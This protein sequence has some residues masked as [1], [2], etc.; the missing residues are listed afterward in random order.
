VLI[1][2]NAIAR[3]IP[4]RDLRLSATHAVYVDGALVPAAAL[5]NGV[6]IRREHHDAAISYFHIEL[7]G[8]D[9]IFAEGLPV[10][11]FIDDGSRQLFDNAE[12]YYDRLSLGG[13]RRALQSD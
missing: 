13:D 7:E 10:E 2:A 5:V 12:E 4:D 8:H 11:T 3:G 9:I 1:R 6:S